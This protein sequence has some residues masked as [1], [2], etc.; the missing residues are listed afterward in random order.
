MSFIL[1]HQNLVANK[2]ALFYRF[3][4]KEKMEQAIAHTKI[5]LGFVDQKYYLLSQEEAQLKYEIKALEREQKVTEKYII[6]NNIS[7]ESQLNILYSLMGLEESPIK[8]EDIRRN[9]QDSKRILNNLVTDEN[10]IYDSNKESVLFK[11]LL[12]NKVRLTKELQ[13]Y[14]YKRDTETEKL[15]E[16]Q[17]KLAFISENINSLQETYEKLPETKQIEADLQQILSI[18]P[19][20]EKLAEEKGRTAKGSEKIAEVE[21][22]LR[23]KKE[24]NSTIENEIESLKKQRIDNQLLLEVGNWYEK[25]H[26]LSENKNKQQQ[27][28]QETTRQLQNIID[29]LSNFALFKKG[30]VPNYKEKITIE[31]ESIKKKKDT[32]QQKCNQLELQ[33]QLS[34]YTKELHKGNPCPLCGSLEH[35]SV[36]H[37]EDVSTELAS[38]QK[39]IKE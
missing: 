9:A 11:N 19:L 14:I 21:K 10:I 8:M 17:D 35:P 38:T 12:D 6:E 31:K 2:H 7:I 20:Q 24:F 32:L 29:E 4:E 23:D 34:H 25:D 37:F 28:I 27:K 3:D 22:E 1:Q 15:K 30:F 33:R 18:F 39:E 5:F 36:A 16:V 26:A 13:S